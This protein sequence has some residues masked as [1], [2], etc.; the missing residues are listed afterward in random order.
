M[1]LKLVLLVLVVIINKSE[2]I[3]SLVTL[4]KGLLVLDLT[5]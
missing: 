3:I 5:V 4:Y 2:N 1:A